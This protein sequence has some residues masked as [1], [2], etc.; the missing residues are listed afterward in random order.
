MLITKTILYRKLVMSMAFSKS[1]RKDM[2]NLIYTFFSKLDPTGKNTEKYKIF[3]GKM[4][5]TQF[6]S[7]FDNFFK[8]KS[9]YL[10]LDIIGYETEPTIKSIE[11]A[12]K[13]LGVPLFEYVIQPNIRRDGSKAVTTAKKVP[14]GYIHMK[15]MQQMVR[16]KNSSST[17]AEQRDPRTG[18]V[19]GDDKDT[20]F[21][22]DENY[23]LMAY[24][25]NQCLREF[26]SFRADDLSMKQE[27]YTNIRKQGYVS[28]D[29]LTDDVDNKTALN[30]LDVYMTGM[31]MKTDLV[32]PGYILNRN[33]EKNEKNN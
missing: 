19:T 13:V 14:V 30:T 22:I 11:N 16:K 1:V 25:A 27:A 9:S 26:L 4:S 8:D 5:D 10:T 17:K 18:Q 21:S 33:L 6:K 28:M 29:E 7:F 15:T 2:E 20:Q 24:N 3:F 32:N 12:A 31:H 23:G